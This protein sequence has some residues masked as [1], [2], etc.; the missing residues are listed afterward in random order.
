[1]ALKTFILENS[2]TKK[3]R[4][5]DI[6]NAVREFLKEPKAKI[7]YDENGERP[8]VENTAKKHY[9][10]V[11]RAGKVMLCTLCDK[12]VGIDG[13]YLPRILAPENKVDYL[14]LAERFF[15]DDEVEYIRDSAKGTEA[16]TFVKLWT[17]KEA[18]TKCIGKTIEEFPKFSVVDGTKLL[19]KVGNVPLRKFSIKFPEC[20]DYLF[21]IAGL[22]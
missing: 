16:E 13:E 20:E 1:M 10:S 2:S 9:I 6:Q 11:A 12:P 14:V 3:Q 7:V 18:Y 4:R 19:S 22:E 21:V 17:R 5:S 15:T 8:T